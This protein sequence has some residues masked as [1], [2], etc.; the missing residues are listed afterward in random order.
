MKN[1]RRM[2]IFAASEDLVEEEL[3]MFI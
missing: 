3:T 2:H 1:I